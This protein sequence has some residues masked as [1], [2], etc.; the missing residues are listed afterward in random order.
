[1]L[2]NILCPDFNDGGCEIENINR[3]IFLS[4]ICSLFF[5]TIKSVFLFLTAG[6]WAR[7]FL[8]LNLN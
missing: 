2:S 1:M 4:K 8:G 7:N 3:Q 6:S 5:N